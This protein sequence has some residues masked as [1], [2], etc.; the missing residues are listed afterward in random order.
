VACRLE[1]ALHPL[2]QSGRLV[3]ILRAVVE[4]FTQ[5]VLDSGQDLGYRRAVTPEP[6]RDDDSRHV[7]QA[8][9]Q[10]TEELLGSF[11]VSS[12]LDEDVQHLT[13][14]V[15]CSP[16][17]V[18]T[19]VDTD[20]HLIQVP[21]IT[22]S[23]TPTTQAI[24]ISLPELQAPLANS[25]VGEGDAAHRHVAAIERS[26]GE[27]QRIIPHECFCCTTAELS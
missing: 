8:L 1:P 21:Q 26:G 3:R 2:A 14:L 19:A 23:G 7:L 9:Q 25:L 22:W 13:F 10:L 20:E 11:L 16:E 24:S 12:A 15:H 17:V 5:P 18:N 4:S 6:I 27:H